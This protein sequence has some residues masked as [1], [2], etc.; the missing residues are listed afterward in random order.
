MLRLAEMNWGCRDAKTSQPAA[1]ERKEEKEADL[2]GREKRSL[3]VADEKGQGE[4]F[5]VVMRGCCWGRSWD[6]D[7]C[8]WDNHALPD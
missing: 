5:V 6:G 3:A 1:S 4:V 2:T 8:R 7:G